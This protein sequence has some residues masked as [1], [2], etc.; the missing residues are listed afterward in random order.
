M[1][2][3][4][5][6]APQL[7]DLPKPL[8]NIADVISRL[9]QA[10]LKAEAEVFEQCLRTTAEPVVKGEITAGKLKW[11]GIRLVRYVAGN[12]SWLEQRGKR[13]SPIVQLELPKLGLNAN[14]L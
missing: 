11:R 5:I 8:F 9:H 13:I 4:K 2:L 3:K 14:G 7:K 1:Q 6:E 10:H 12:Q